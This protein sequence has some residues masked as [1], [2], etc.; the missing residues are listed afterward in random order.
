MEKMTSID[1]FKDI[2]EVEKRITNLGLKLITLVKPVM[3]LMDIRIRKLR[4]RSQ[5]ISMV[6]KNK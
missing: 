6:I 5:G 1:K 2:D 3:S 4:K